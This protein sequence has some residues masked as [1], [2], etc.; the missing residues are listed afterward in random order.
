MT[1]LVALVAYALGATHLEVTF[2]RACGAYDQR[3]MLVMLLVSPWL[4]GVSHY[5]G[6]MR[7]RCICCSRGTVVLGDHRRRR[8][9]RAGLVEMRGGGNVL[10]RRRCSGSTALVGPEVPYPQ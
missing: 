5:G 7:S 8:G 1:F 6:G 4:L 3:T 10:R 2:L 9:W